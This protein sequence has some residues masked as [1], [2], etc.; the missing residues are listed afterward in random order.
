[1]NKLQPT[2]YAV[3]RVL[4]ETGKSLSPLAIAEEANIDTTS[5]NLRFI[6]DECFYGVE[7]GALSYR[8]LRGQ[9]KNGAVFFWWSQQ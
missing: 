8:D 4:R 1:M 6:Q 3:Y 5:E 7:N 2:A 9:G